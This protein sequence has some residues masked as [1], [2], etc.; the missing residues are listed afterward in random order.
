VVTRDTELRIGQRD[1]AALDDRMLVLDFQAGDP[2]AFV[3]IHR[4]YGGLARHVC[5]RF[6]R[7]RQDADEAFQETMIR[8]FQGLFR[9]NG[10][11]ALQPW[12]ARIATN[13]S[14][15]LLR[16][17]ARRPP[18]EDGAIEDGELPDSADGP[19]EA[20][21]RLVQRDL[22]LSVLE[23]LPEKH[24][25]A[26]VLREMDGRSHREI[27]KTLG[28]TPAQAKALIHRA[29]GSFRRGWLRAV[30]DRGGLAGV[31]LL[32]LLWLLRV[33]DV[34]RRLV[35]R[36]GPA[37][38]QAAQVA[39]PEVVTAAASSPAVASGVATGLAERLVAAGVTL[40]LAGGVTVAAVKAGRDRA[41]PVDRAAAPA[42]VQSA[43][44]SPVAAVPPSPTPAPDEVARNGDRQQEAGRDRGDREG[45]GEGTKAEGTPPP[46][47]GPPATDPPATDP[48]ATEPPETIPPAPD[49]AFSFTTL[50]VSVES[51]GCD[52]T[53]RL[54]T[55]T[56]TGTPAEGVTFGQEVEGAVF[57]AGGD[58]TWPFW[59]SFEGSAGPDGGSLDAGFMIGSAG[60]LYWYDAS[61]QV[62]ETIE[63][64]D[65]ATVYRFAGTYWLRPDQDPVAGIPRLGT[66]SMS[67]AVWAD[68]TVYLGSVTLDGS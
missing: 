54:I 16:A 7:N 49:W 17:S 59:L 37:T 18:L 42:L 64:E 61:G 32:P 35:D 24:R 46:T 1:Y 15:D 31:A 13:V 21:E 65:G 25:A 9:F 26:L 45:R 30:A 23:D 8:V 2:E 41:E 43:S 55:S 44:P 38:Q 53:P 68:G 57:D 50:G 66:F 52:T 28:I 62:V 12:I 56:T 58:P 19:E 4:R 3:E 36:A 63:S 67:L 22:V 40:V 39:T 51:C 27:A 33:G 47:T 34:A 10:R 60:G 48:P 6:L 20:Y 5:G 29:K 11:Y 14:L